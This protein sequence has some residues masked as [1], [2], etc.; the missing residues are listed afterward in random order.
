MELPK[1]NLNEDPHGIILLYDN[2]ESTKRRL[3]SIGVDS[4]SYST[5]LLPIILSK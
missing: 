4:D 3:K 5:V 1:I 2:L